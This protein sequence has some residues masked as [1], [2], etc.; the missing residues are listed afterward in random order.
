LVKTIIKSWSSE[1]IFDQFSE[2]LKANCAWLKLLAVK[3]SV[4]HGLFEKRKEQNGNGDFLKA[5]VE[6]SEQTPALALSCS[7]CSYSIVG[8]WIIFF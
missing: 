3:L 6:K 7:R 2:E 4:L 5:R 8:L 1:L